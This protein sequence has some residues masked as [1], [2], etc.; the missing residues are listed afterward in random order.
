MIRIILAMKLE[1]CLAI[2]TIY[3]VLTFQKDQMGKTQA[4]ARKQFC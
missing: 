4:I 1:Q 2:E 3:L